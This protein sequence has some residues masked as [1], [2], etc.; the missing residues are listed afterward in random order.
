MGCGDRFKHLVTPRETDWLSV[1]WREYGMRKAAAD[2][3]ANLVKEARDHL[4]ERLK[5]AELEGELPRSVDAYLER[6][7]ALPSSTFWDMRPDSELVEVV[8]SNVEDGACTLERLEDA[9]LVT[10]PDYVSPV[11]EVTPPSEPWGW[12]DYLAVAGIVGAAGVATWFVAA[13]ITSNRRDTE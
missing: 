3:L 11:A 6:W 10:Q 12:A 8:Q 4:E 2:H 7:K 13:R 1:G 5:P 9:I